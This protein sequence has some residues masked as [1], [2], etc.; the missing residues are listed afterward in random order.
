M[1][2]CRVCQMDSY[3]GL[4]YMAEGA[5]WYRLFCRK[6]YF[7]APHLADIFVEA[8]LERTGLRK[9]HCETRFFLYNGNACKVLKSPRRMC[10]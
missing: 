1:D 5:G 9:Y 4:P 10:R 6:C 7:L 8:L 2:Y 3:A